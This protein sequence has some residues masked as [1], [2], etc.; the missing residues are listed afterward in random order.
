LQCGLGA[1][2]L[3]YELD[4]G[5]ESKSRDY[6]PQQLGPRHGEH[7]CKEGEHDEGGK[8][9]CAIGGDGRMAGK[10]AEHK[11][12]EHGCDGKQAEQQKTAAEG[13]AAELP[14]QAKC[15][16]Y[17]DGCLEKKGEQR[18]SAVKR[19]VSAGFKTGD[20]SEEQSGSQRIKRDQNRKRGQA[21]RD[22]ASKNGDNERALQG[23]TSGPDDDIDC[24]SR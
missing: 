9:L 21:S 14:Y 13:P 8:S 11:P 22:T 1:G 4:R 2:S 5:E 6:A 24:G 20:K 7:P 3:R 10:P 18:K 15:D 19:F 12:G 16:L 23:K 17:V